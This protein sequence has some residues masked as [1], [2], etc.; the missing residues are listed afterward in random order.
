MISPT[1]L[2]VDSR[3]L[4]D[5]FQR[6]CDCGA[7]LCGTPSEEAARALL[8]DLGAAATGVPARAEPLP[9]RGW[10]GLCATLS[11]P[12]HPAIP[13]HPLVRSVSTGDAPLEAEFLDLG[14][15][16][17]ADFDTAA[18]RVRGRIV[19]V[20]HEHMFAPDTIHRRVKYNRAMAEGAVGFLIVS[21]VAGSLVSGSTGR[22][23]N[24]PG[25]PAAGISPATA[26]LLRSQPTGAPIKL[27]IRTEETDAQTENLFFDLPGETDEWIVLTA[28]IDGHDLAESAMDN[29]SGL[30]VVLTA[31]DAIRRASQGRRN[32]R[33]LRVAFYTLEEWA[34]TGS[35]TSLER[36]SPS[37][38]AQIAACI[39][40][41]AV[42]YDPAL[43]ALTSDFPNLGP[44]LQACAKIHNL[45][46]KIH[47][48]LQPNSDH[49]N[50]AR[51]G[52]PAFRLVAG[53]GTG[54]GPGGD[55]LTDRDTRDRV[56]LP[57]LTD[58]AR[59]TATTSLA[60]LQAEENLKGWLVG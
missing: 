55:L 18:G 17:P 53:F 36:M 44:A 57:L 1:H 23:A 9:Y 28:H 42:G 13:A 7:R 3:I 60:F 41:D 32:R 31:A 49:A 24:E 48:P 30:A 26:E 51:H 22:A 19:M 54:S 16:S 5:A 11:L 45:P 59:F 12:G 14:R 27:T 29:A 40:I 4:S 8:R 25:I 33:G 46:L 21:P 20:R 43:A 2:D 37:E 10:R 6:I 56:K 58:V 34:L 38:R 35:A 39:N 52:I 47:E 50:F 15:G